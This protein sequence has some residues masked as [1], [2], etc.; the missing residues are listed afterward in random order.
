ME[1]LPSEISLNT[2]D[3]FKMVMSLFESTIPKKVC[4]IPKSC[5]ANAS[6]YDY[7]DK[8]ELSLQLDKIS[9]FQCIQSMEPSRYGKPH[10][11]PICKILLTLLLLGLL[12]YSS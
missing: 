5:D 1:V 9:I 6:D 8:I 2:L 12:Q 7:L 10:A 4:Q 3:W 11:C